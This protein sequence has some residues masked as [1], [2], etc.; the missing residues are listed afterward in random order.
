M[1]PKGPRGHDLQPTPPP[2]R[3]SGRPSQAGSE[4]PSRARG[5]AVGIEREESLHW[6]N[7]AYGEPPSSGRFLHS[8]A[9][10]GSKAYFF[11]GHDGRKGHLQS[12]TVVR[13]ELSPSVSWESTNLLQQL[14]T[15]FARSQFCSCRIDDRV[16]IFG[17]WDGSRR[18]LPMIVLDPDE[19][20]LN[21]VET[22]GDSPCH[23]CFGAAASVHTRIIVFGGCAKRTE[24]RV[25]MLDVQGGDD[26]LLMWSQGSTQQAPSKRSSHAMASVGRRV[27]V[28]GGKDADGQPLG[29]L[30]CYEVDVAS[31]SGAGSAW[32]QQPAATGDSPSPRF[33]HAMAAMGDVIY[34]F[35]GMG[36]PNA[37]PSSPASPGVSP[38]L[39][40]LNDL[41]R[42][43][44]SG[45]S[46]TWQLVSVEAGP[47]RCPS[48]RMYH[49]L[50]A[51]ESI[52]CVYGGR[53]DTTSPALGDLWTMETNLGGPV[54]AEAENA[55]SET[56]S[57]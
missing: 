16:Y 21:E 44:C 26:S 24:S 50:T 7:I 5:S 4:S 12:E 39:R 47:G 33:G 1:P 17:G 38:A 28:F 51:V 14:S 54:D 53:P 57:Q 36:L 22:S 19:G 29:D 56:P 23:I 30:H 49:T 9:A 41:W 52:L 18:G 13:A 46:P 11:G 27:W 2:G 32:I 40:T 15:P 45:P 55:I 3:A 6:E 8:A 31:P 37:S 20:T 48:A 10:I 42:L 35:G 43:D 25:W 34:L